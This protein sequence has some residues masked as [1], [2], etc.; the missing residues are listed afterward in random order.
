M[1]TVETIASLPWV[2]RH[3]PSGLDER[4]QATLTGIRQLLT[5]FESIGTGTRFGTV[6]RSYA[7]EYLSL[8]RWSDLSLDRLIAGVESGWPGIGRIETMSTDFRQGPNY[9]FIIDDGVVFH[10]PETDANADIGAL[11]KKYGKRNKSLVKSFLGNARAASKYFVVFVPSRDIPVEEIGALSAAMR[12]YNPS[13]TLLCVHRS[14]DPTL[15]G[16]I[17]VQSPNLIYG[18]VRER[19]EAIEDGLAW[20]DWIKVC[21]KADSVWSAGK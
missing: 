10:T 6:Q 18:H 3:F 5:R 13:N 15:A 14:T 17:S 12:K 20:A 11:K 2:R 4:Q 8:L 1:S 21:R 7:H 16:E 19:D 9:F